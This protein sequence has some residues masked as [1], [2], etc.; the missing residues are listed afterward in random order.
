MMEGSRNKK[1]NKIGRQITT[2]A[3][4]NPITHFFFFFIFS[5]LQIERMINYVFLSVLIKEY[6]CAMRMEGNNYLTIL[7]LNNMYF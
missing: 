6:N 1:L 4:V 5:Y 7:F 2:T 3:T